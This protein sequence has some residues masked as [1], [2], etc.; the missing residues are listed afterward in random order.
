MGVLFYLILFADGR[1]DFKP[2]CTFIVR[3]EESLA[4]IFSASAA[5]AGTFWR[6]SKL[7]F[8]PISE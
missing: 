4:A 8:E 6:L 2:G 5:I 1:D 3:A 7:N